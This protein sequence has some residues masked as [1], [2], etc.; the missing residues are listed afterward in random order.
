[1]EGLL[2]SNYSRLWDG[3]ESGW[4]LLQIHRHTSAV[5]VLFDELGAP[6]Q[7]VQALRRVMPEFNRLP[8]LQAIQQLR[9]RQRV[10]LGE[11]DTPPKPCRACCTVQGD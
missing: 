11:F 4:V 5:A 7:E 9:G 8:A 10:Y 3:T 2:Q 6:P 1:M